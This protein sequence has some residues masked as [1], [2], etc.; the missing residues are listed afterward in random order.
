MGGISQMIED[1]VEGRLYSGKPPDI[2]GLAEGCLTY[3]RDADMRRRHG[4]AARAR[5]EQDF[6]ARKHARRLQDEM[7][8]CVGI[9]A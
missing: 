6:D 5:I 4:A 9:G 8:R 2:E 7:F 3:F 1:G